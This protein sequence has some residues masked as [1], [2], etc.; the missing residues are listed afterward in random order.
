MKT[1]RLKKLESL[2]AATTKTA[3][4]IYQLKSEPGKFYNL[5]GSPY[6]GQPL[7]PFAG[8]F[9]FLD[10][11]DAKEIFQLYSSDK[12]FEKIRSNYGIKSH[13]TNL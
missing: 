9:T 10:H 12:V 13:I 4:P 1:N 6:T 2:K 5:D 11:E 7:D 8:K 3:L